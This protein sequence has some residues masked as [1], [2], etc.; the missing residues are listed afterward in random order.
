MFV[1]RISQGA[2]TFL[3]VYHRHVRL[4]ERFRLHEAAYKTPTILSLSP[5]SQ[6]AQ[7]VTPNS[8]PSY[9]TTNAMET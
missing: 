9:S 7:F 1:L 2:D 3:G 6:L 4:T 5:F 8:I